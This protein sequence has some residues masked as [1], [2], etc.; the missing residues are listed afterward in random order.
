MNTNRLGLRLGT[1]VALV[2]AGSTVGCGDD[3]T[4]VRTSSLDAGGTGLGTTTDTGVT[5][6]DDG[7]VEATPGDDGSSVTSPDSG[8]A[9]A[10]TSDAATCNSCS[11]P[12]VDFHNACSSQVGGCVPFTGTVPP[13]PTVN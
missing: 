12:S 8:T 5:P 13:H 6:V 2:L 3:S 11:S 9:P 4:T 1:L 7:S 10:C